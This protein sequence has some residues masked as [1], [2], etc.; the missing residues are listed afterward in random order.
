MNFKTCSLQWS[1]TIN[2]HLEIDTS[3]LIFVNS[4]IASSM[5]QSIFVISI[6]VTSL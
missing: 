5:G 6:T 3:D 4:V 2:S 1:D